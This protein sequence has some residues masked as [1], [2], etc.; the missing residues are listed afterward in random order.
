ML[1]QPT[2][3]DAMRG[4]L[5][6]LQERGLTEYGSDIP[7]ELVHEI[8]GIDV[9]DVAEKSVFDRIAMV[10]LAAIDYCRNVLIGQG[11]YLQGTPSGYRVLL[12]SENKAQIDSYMGSADRKLS[13]ALKLSRNTPAQSEAKLDQT[14]ARIMLKRTGMRGSF[15]DD[16]QSM[17]A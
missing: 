10:E 6:A 7:A 3:R 5:T 4:L 1:E 15:Q 11:K 13:R 2:K 9:P 12:P 17:A 14:E 16:R 8:L